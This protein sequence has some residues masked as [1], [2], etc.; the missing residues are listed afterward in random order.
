VSLTDILEVDERCERAWAAGF[1]DAEGWAA[2]FK[3]H[4][5]THPV[6]Q[7]NQADGSG[8]PESLE[9]FQAAVGVGRIG[10][11]QRAAGRIDLYRWVASS[12]ADVTRAFVVLVPW[13]GPVKRT[14]LV[15]AV[16]PQ[17]PAACES[18]SEELLAWAAGLFDGDG[19]TCFAKHRTHAGYRTAEMSLT[20]SSAE[21]APDVLVRF[22]RAV[23]V[24]RLY[25]PY[26]G[27]E[28]WAPVYR[29]KALRFSDVE[30]AAHAMWPWLGGRKRSQAEAV[31]AAVRTQTPLPRG[32]R[33]WG[34]RKTHCVNGHEYATARIRAYRARRGGSERRASQQCLACVRIYARRRYANKRAPRPDGRG[35]L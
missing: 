23:G 12:R 32:N 25:R 2:A 29:W 13:L 16:G 18:A 20:Q 21:G 17:S 10:G 22:L 31:L 26:G 19:S 14:Q 11:P 3:R 28:T 24:G 35:A 4:G 34:N 8:V 6:A 1:F 27:N 5:G 30:H 33:V 15:H 7:I 9:R